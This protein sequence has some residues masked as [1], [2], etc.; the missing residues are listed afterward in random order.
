MLLWYPPSVYWVTDD[1]DLMF[2]NTF[3][4]L[5]IIKPSHHHCNQSS[6]TQRI[7]LWVLR[8]C[9]C[10]YKLHNYGLWSLHRLLL[11][12]ISN[13]IKSTKTQSAAPTL[14]LA[15]MMIFSATYE[16]LTSSLRGSPLSEDQPHL[17]MRLWMLTIWTELSLSTSPSILWSRAALLQ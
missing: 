13:Q 14:R 10:S 3:W 9:Y 17:C 16:S 1:K 11:R 6:I 4:C 7:S 12:W 8:F 5:Y 2:T 15:P